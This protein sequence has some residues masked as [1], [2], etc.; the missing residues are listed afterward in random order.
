[1]LGA[2]RKTLCGVLRVVEQQAHKVYRS[3]KEQRDDPGQV[4]GFLCAGFWNWGW[5]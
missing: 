2:R 3:W 4:P 5:R 1:M